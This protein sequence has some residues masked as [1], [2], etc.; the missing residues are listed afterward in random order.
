MRR[1]LRFNSITI[2]LLACASCANPVVKQQCMKVGMVS[3]LVAHAALL[4]LDVYA[5]GTPCLN[6]ATVGSSA[7][8]PVLSHTFTQGQAVKLDVPPGRRTLVLTAYADRAATQL[9]GSGCIEEDLKP[10]S[11]VCFNLIVHETVDLSAVVE[12]PADLA[13]DHAPADLAKCTA[14]GC[15][16]SAT[17]ADTCPANQYCGTSG[18]CVSGC[19]LNSDCTG[20]A[21]SAD[22]GAPRNLCNTTTHQC[23]ECQATEDC[24]DGKL[25]SP[26]GVCV[27][28]C[29]LQ[30]GKSCPSPLTCCNNLCIDTRSDLLNCGGCGT[31]C[32]GGDTLCCNS[33][34]ANPLSNVA[35][36]GGCGRACA[37]GGSVATAQCGGGVCTST[38]EPGSGNCI[39]PEFPAADDGCETATN[40]VEACGACGV[41]CDTTSG[42]SG[43]ASC[44]LPDGGVA[45]C[46]YAGCLNNY[47]DCLSTAPNSDGCETL[48]RTATNCGACNRKCDTLTSTGATCA[49]GTC[50]YSGCIAGFQ[51]CDI[52]SPPEGNKN[53]CET[54]IT[55]VANC[56][57]CGR[58]CD[59]SSGY[60]GAPSC[61]P[62]DGG[63]AACSYNGCAANR[64]DCDQSASNVNGCETDLT[65]DV[66]NC[67]AC[68]AQCNSTGAMTRACNGTKC[69]YTC[70][71]GWYDC[72]SGGL[73]TNG[74][75]C[76]TAS[77]ASEGTAGCCGLS[78]QYQHSNGIGQHYYDCTAL[79]TYT[80]NEAQAACVA[81]S[82]SL[83][84]CKQFTCIL[85]S[86]GKAT[87]DLLICDN[88]GCPT[89]SPPGCTCNCWDY[90]TS[91]N[92]GGGP[93][94]PGHVST[95]CGCPTTSDPS[96]H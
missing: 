52:N 15:P 92:P 94:A 17:P 65:S 70:S 44:V 12:T 7:G 5:S 34:C 29:D 41:H 3:D 59:V 54:P 87:N 27:I 79:D 66:N 37:T 16:C 46:H 10:G 80:V 57:G 53:G 60:S 35:H 43:A 69:T 93:T 2:L 61:S 58:A 90:P 63:S 40:T 62:V 56:G 45:A 82:G 78:C 25:C 49:S 32:T 74:C 72:N 76:Q 6:G 18:A 75:E 85:P 11:E 55:T 24:P 36:C 95:T 64:G 9:S 86:N 20:M 26:S 30:H 19:K 96:W 84:L 68:G 67:T 14:V 31:L 4:R 88:N 42:N 28:G 89:G 81:S 8:A 73:D 23:N 50:Q 21:A 13:S 1:R 39:K 51:D 47:G 77:T 91:G 22:G 71:T 48:L 33:Q 83:S 38:C